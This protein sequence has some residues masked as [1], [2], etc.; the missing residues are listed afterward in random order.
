MKKTILIAL[1]FIGINGFAQTDN[2]KLNRKEAI[3]LDSIGQT[4]DKEKKYIEAVEYYENALKSDSTYGQAIYN[5][6]MALY[7]SHIKSC[8][9]LNLCNEF[10]KAYNYGA[11]ISDETLFFYGCKLKRRK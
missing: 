3:R 4:F 6:A 11:R 5:L 1:L 2:L 9:P 8:N 7:N 10:Q